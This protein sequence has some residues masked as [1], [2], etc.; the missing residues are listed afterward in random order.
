MSD[1]PTLLANIPDEFKP[2]VALGI[3][4]LMLVG[5]VLLHGAG[6]HR[7]IKLQKRREQRLSVRRHKV[8]EAAFLF[9]WSVFL[10]LG[11]HIMGIVLWA[12]SLSHLGLLARAYDAIYFCANAYTTLGYGSV[13][14]E[15]HWRNVSP[16]IGLSGLFTFAW[17]TSALVEVVASNGRILEK[18][19]AEREH[20]LQ[21][22]L[23]LA[24]EAWDAVKKE[25]EAVRSER[26]TTG[27]RISGASLFDRCR[28]W[29]EERKRVEEFQRAAISKIAELR[30]KER[31]DEEKL[32]LD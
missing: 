10:M 2:I 29:K 25:E 8:A 13:D 6:L 4:A 16:I 28:S 26:R 5:L 1:I 11:L 32:K 22:R 19:A 18:Q 31:H 14:L 30:Q 20:E 15:Q 17:T 27:M 9:G 7:I 23:A 3:G 21:L 24:K 12:F